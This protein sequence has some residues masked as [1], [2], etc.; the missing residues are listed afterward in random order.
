MSQ[1]LES[2]FIQ[3]DRYAC[4]LDT[5]LDDIPYRNQNY[6]LSHLALGLDHASRRLI[7]VLNL[8]GTRLSD[9][10][11]VGQRAALLKTYEIMAVNGLTRCNRLKEKLAMKM[12]KI[13][14]DMEH[15]PSFCGAN[16]IFRTSAPSYIDIRL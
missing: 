14:R 16:R 1:S 7:R 11:A 4:A 3:F 6:A 8:A 9:A 5:R 2:A 10:G 15:K 13:K 12:K